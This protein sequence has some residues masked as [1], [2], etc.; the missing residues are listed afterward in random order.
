MNIVLGCSADKKLK[1]GAYIIFKGGKRIVS[2]SFNIGDKGTDA[3]LKEYVFESIIKGLRGVRNIVNHEDLLLIEV[4]NGHMA[5][6]LNGSREYKG[7]NKYLDEISEIIDTLD[8]RYMFAKSN[9]KEVKKIL[10]V[11]EELKTQ[12]ILE[13]FEGM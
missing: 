3:T 1:R 9:V 11:K 12:G 10:E 8:C 13:A 6:W 2:E 5:E 7:Y 4:P